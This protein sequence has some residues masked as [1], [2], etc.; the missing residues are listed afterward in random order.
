VL[1]A[2]LVVAPALARQ[3][4]KRE[5]SYVVSRL[6]SDIPGRADKLDSDLVNAWGLAA[7]PGSP[8]WV[9][10]NGT[11][12][13]TL[14]TA[15]GTKQGLIVSVPGNPSGMVANAGSNFPVTNGSTSGTARFIFD[16]EGGQILGWAPNVDGTHAL[17]AVD[18]SNIGAV[19]K[20]LAINPTADRLYAADFH[21]GQVDVFDGSFTELS[22]PGAFV[23][24]GLDKGY[25]P[26]GIQT[27]GN[28]VFVSYAKQDADRHDD[29][30]GHGHG[31]VDAYD[32]NGNFIERVATHDQ[33][34]SPWGLAMAPAMWGKFGGDLL[35]G[36]FGD[37]Q[38]N[39]YHRVGP[40][41][42]VRDGELRRSTNEPIS[43]D[44]LW[45]LQFGMGSPNNGPTDTLFYTSGPGDEGHGQFGTI[46]VHP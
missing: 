41:D 6:V 9:N 43:L 27:I 32:L 2:T 10:D 4:A 24:P 22:M 40:G 36:N 45:A 44:G 35:V 8:W 5:N 21:N 18:R 14:Y 37:G 33:L 16:T 34:D 13:S 1:A 28:E 25:A 42:W 17:V 3:G 31:F 23:D 30:A 38:I 19:F 15:D 39:A 20:G 7:L 46:T 11:N 12:L 29:V 26:F